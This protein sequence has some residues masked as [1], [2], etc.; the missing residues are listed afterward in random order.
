MDNAKE[1]IVQNWNKIFMD[2]NIV[3][4]M[5]VVIS[6]K[7]DMKQLLLVKKDASIATYLAL[8]INILIVKLV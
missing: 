1:R 3:R 2:V 8:R 7:M 5:D 4:L 6:A